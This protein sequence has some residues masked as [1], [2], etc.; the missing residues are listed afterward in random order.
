MTPGRFDPERTLAAIH[1]LR[2][3]VLIAVPTLFRRLLA[4]GDALQSYDLT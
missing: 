4:L 1:R 2:P 3:T